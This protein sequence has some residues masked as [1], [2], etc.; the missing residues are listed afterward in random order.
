[1][2]G[3]LDGELVP[4]VVMSNCTVG[5]GLHALLRGYKD[6]PAAALRELRAGELARRIG[7]WLATDPPGELNRIGTWDVLTVVP[8][9][10]RRRAPAEG[11]VRR[12]PALAERH[13]RL[14]RRGP[15][16]VDH[17]RAAPLAYLVAPGAPRPDDR[18]GRVV[19]FDDCLTTGARAQSAAFAL[20]RAG[21]P[22]V[23]ILVVA[24]AG[25]RFD[26]SGRQPR[27]P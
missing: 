4:V 27:N 8:S 5:D 24:R 7:E 21:F 25:R 13:R 10:R 17:L 18:S 3:Q 12:I 2:A 23:G 9:S 1:V 14:L 22:V 19:V 26:G 20:R 6:G 16:P 11:L 15:A